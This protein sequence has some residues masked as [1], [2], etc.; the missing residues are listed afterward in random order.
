MVHC[1]SLYMSPLYTPPPQTTFAKNFLLIREIWV[2]WFKCSAWLIFFIVSMFTNTHRERG[3]E[4]EGRTHVAQQID[5]DNDDYTKSFLKSR[6]HL[7]WN[8]QCICAFF[9]ICALCA[10]LWQRSLLMLLQCKCGGDNFPISSISWTSKCQTF[11][12]FSNST[13]VLIY[14]EDGRM[15]CASVAH[16]QSNIPL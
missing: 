9:L 7:L 1:F 12:D 13:A 11:S 4:G 14:I 10:R 2:S 6:S 16:T 3:R 8:S 15:T 5:N